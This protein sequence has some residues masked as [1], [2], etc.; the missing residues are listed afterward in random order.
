MGNVLAVEGVS[1]GSYEVDFESGLERDFVFD[2]YMDE[3]EDV[4]A[5]GALSDYVELDRDEVVGS[6]SVVVSLKLPE[7]LDAHEF[8]NSTVGEFGVNNI[9][10]VVGDV[11]GLIKV[12]VEYP[13]MF[14]GLDF[15][16]LDVNVGEDIEV[17]LK[18]LNLGRKKAYF[19]GSVEVYGERSEVGSRKSE[20]EG[21][22]ASERELIEEFSLNSD[23]INVSGEKNFNF[24]LDGEDYSA[25]DYLVVARVDYGRGWSV[26]ES[27][28][29]VGEF[30]LKIVNYTREIGDNIERFEIEIES[31]WNGRMSEVFG[32]VR[33]VDLNGKSVGEFDSSIIS[34]GAWEKSV[35]VGFFN[36]R[37]LEGKVVMNIDVHYDGEVVSDV[38]SV[39]IVKGISLWFWFGGVLLL[40]VLG[41]L[42]WRIFRT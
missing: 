22:G 28:F 42:G 19:R 23:E 25:G 26:E 14:V 7:V 41:F 37:G 3:K 35:L 5:E 34:L 13:E 2:F 24:L 20:V 9:W 40:A 17:G 27:V 21:Q 38:V 29:R 6:G 18:V 10:I 12:N 1:P 30:G 11:R 8:V 16:V 4:Y 31:L 33:V 32:E 39:N 15:S 36:A